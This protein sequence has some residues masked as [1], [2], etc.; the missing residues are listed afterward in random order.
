MAWQ[1]LALYLP[2]FLDGL[3]GWGLLLLRVIWGTII[4]LYGVPMVKNPLHWLDLGG[5]PSGVP[6]FL[7]AI[8]AFTIFMGGIAI[9]AGLLTPLAAL[10]LAGAMAFALWLHLKNGN[11]LIK[12]PPDA[13]GDSYEASLVYLAIALLFLFVGPGNFSIDSIL[14]R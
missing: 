4:V 2:P 1:N 11:P 5:K 7:Q 3:A 10:G 12:Q 13:A 9:I 6:G 8:G 14:F